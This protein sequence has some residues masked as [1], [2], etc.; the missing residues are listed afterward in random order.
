VA[1]KITTVRQRAP[2]AASDPIARRLHN[3][4][5]TAAPFHSPVDVVKWFGAVQA[6]EYAVARWALGLRCAGVDDAAVARAFDAGAILRTHVMRPT[7]HFVTPADIRWMLALTAPRISAAMA[8]Y[9]RTLELTPRVFTRSHDIIA[10][11]LEGGRFLTRADLAAAL[12][13]RGL[14][15]AGHRLGRLMLQAEIDQVICSGPRRE[16][17]FTYA[18]LA[19]RVPRAK[20][21]SR[22]ASLA[23]LTRRYFSSHGPA[24]VRD[25]GWWS[26]LT[27]KDARLGIEL[28]KPA[29]VRE[30]AGDLTYWSSPDTSEPVSAAQATYLL[31]IYDEYLIAYKNRELVIGPTG[32]TDAIAAFAGG[33]PHHVI[34]GGRLVG[35]WSRTVAGE[36]LTITIRPYRPLSRAE[37]SQVRRAAERFGAFQ[38]MP[39]VTQFRST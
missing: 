9:N 10:R 35:S 5:L 26:G 22:E 38:G 32:A 30:D 36:S 12:E 4:R 7:W 27:M 3:Q 11:A 1:T 29:L 13:R 19:D 25:Y 28:C 2:R 16:K 24:T 17:Q 37:M 20:A 33:F 18:L 15:A 8:S 34:V 31:P 6:Q 14:Q 21:L 23:E 39:V